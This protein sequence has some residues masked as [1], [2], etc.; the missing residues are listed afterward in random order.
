MPNFTAHNIRLP[1]GTTTR[2][3]DTFTMDQSP[4]LGATL[5]MLNLVF[6]GGLKGVSIADVGCLEGG[7]A[8]EFA[9]VG[10]RATGIEVRETNFECCLEVQRALDLE[11]LSFVRD[12]ANNIASLGTFDVI[13][14][15]GL[16]YHLD[17][18]RRFL[19]AASSV[20]RKAIFLQTHFAAEEDSAESLTLHSLS[21]IQTHEGVRGRWYPEHDGVPIAQLE[22]M[23]WHSW[24]NQQSF[25]LTKADLLGI[26]QEIGFSL[27]LEQYDGLGNIT[28][29]M[30]VG[31]HKQNDRSLF[32]GIKG[33]T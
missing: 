23:R 9:K 2:P 30:T 15:N 7:Y 17:M 11:N 22:Q 8:A 6:P 29:E 27:V 10:M 16:L 1:N 14:C 20:C 25:W 3:E 18:P 32:V 4:I 31:F 28:E 13:F 12:D 33:D 19:R 21:D 24:N 5:R 26:L